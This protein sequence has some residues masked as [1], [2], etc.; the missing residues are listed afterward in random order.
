VEF[1]LTSFE[2]GV[3]YVFPDCMKE[4]AIA[5]VDLRSVAAHEMGHAIGLGHQPTSVQ[6]T[7]MRAD[8]HDMAPCVTPFDVENARALP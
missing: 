3:I 4:R 7:I 2:H 1:G 8:A 6:P 5:G